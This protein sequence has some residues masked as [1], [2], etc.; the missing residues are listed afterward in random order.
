MQ[1]LFQWVPPPETEDEEA[2]IDPV[3]GKRLFLA[4]DL[5]EAVTVLLVRLNPH[6][7]GVRW[8]R[9]EQMHLTLSFLGNVEPTVEE[10]LKEKLSAIRFRAFFLPGRQ[11]WNF[12]GQ[13][14]TQCHLGR[15][16]SGTSAA[17]PRLPTRAGSRTRRWFGAG[18]SRVA[19]PHH[20]CALS[21]CL[22]GNGS[23]FPEGERGV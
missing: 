20:D 17:L 1:K 5:P 9:P 4:I 23:P 3:I 13:R 7:P 6:L 16:G 12:P 21:R 8:L 19:S 2:V 15:C 11:R 22:R 18:P 10:A 14:K